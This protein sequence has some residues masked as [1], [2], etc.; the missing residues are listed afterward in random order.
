MTKYSSIRTY[1]REIK[2]EIYERSCITLNKNGERCFWGK[3]RKR[4]GDRILYFYPV[5]HSAWQRPLIVGRTVV[6]GMKAG[7]N[8]VVN[9]ER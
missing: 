5:D 6:F 9:T 3:A 7:I 1:E 4:P 8:M 2:I